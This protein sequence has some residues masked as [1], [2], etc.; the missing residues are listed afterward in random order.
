M[1]AALVS[2]A[3]TVVAHAG[4]VWYPVDVDVWN[5]PFNGERIRS[6]HEYEPLDEAGRKWNI[7]VSIPHLK[8]A[9]WLA[10]NYGLIAEAKRLGVG[11]SLYE[12]GGY[13]HLAT[14]RKQ[15]EECLSGG[16]DG[17][18]I[19]AISKDSLEDL[20]EM[21][22]DRGV[23]VIDMIN[24]I[25]SD[26]ISARVA[27]DFWDTGNRAGL[28][29][30]SRKADDTEAVRVAWFPGP[31]GAGWVAAGDAGFREALEGS[32]I[33]IVASRMGD[34]GRATQSAL[35]TEVLK[36][37]ADS[38]DYIVGTAVTAEA[39]VEVLRRRALNDDIRVI[40]YYYSPGVH[41]GI[42]RGYVLAAPTDQQALQARIAVDTMVRILEEKEYFKH[43]APR[44]VLIDGDTQ[45][46][47]DASTALAPRGF[48]PVFSIN[49]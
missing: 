33:E 12:A 1:R 41:R 25:S 43:V 7:C 24:G 23:P 40:S 31:D 10:V 32:S 5:P 36:D 27:V 29:L 26:L 37:H 48:R 44:V 38:L 47:W 22:S 21:A 18:I 20:L 15:I 9:Y 17:L 6:V 28:F 4:E 49:Q 45:L 16:S 30:R 3:L 35:I 42:K 39:A 13:E 11:V 8:D 34:T 19:S 46:D 2:I 14:Q